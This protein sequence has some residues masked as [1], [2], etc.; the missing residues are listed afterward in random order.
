[1]TKKRAYIETTVPNFYYDFRGS[2]AVGSRREATRAWWPTAAER[3]DLVTSMVVVD[4]LSAGTS[5]MTALRLELLGGMHKLPLLAAVADIV[6]V[7]LQNK[8]MP[9][10]PSADALHLALASYFG[11]DF[12]VTWNCRHLANP[13]KAEH[14]RR[15][16][17]RLGL[18]M[19][20]LVTPL[21]LLKE[22]SNARRMDRGRRRD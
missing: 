16:N 14:I 17:T 20:A 21:E 22:D 5:H 7:Y 19:P 10:K 1:M 2:Q 13:N 18:G 3:Y 4:E 15:V 8:L 11:C 12:T 6:Q 9:A